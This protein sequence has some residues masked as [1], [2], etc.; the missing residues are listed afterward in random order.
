[1]AT[2]VGGCGGVH[3]G[4]ICDKFLG[5]VVEF[6]D[7][8]F[9][10]IDE[11]LVDEGRGSFRN[12]FRSCVRLFDVRS[13]CSGSDGSGEDFLHSLKFVALQFTASRFRRR[14]EAVHQSQQISSK[15]ALVRVA[16]EDLLR[17]VCVD[18]DFFTTVMVA[19][20]TEDA[21]DADFC[22][23]TFHIQRDAALRRSGFECGLCLQAID[24]NV[25]NGFVHEA[26]VKCFDACYAPLNSMSQ[27]VN[28]SKRD[29][30]LLALLEMTPATVA[31]IRRASV[32]FDD[33]P[34][35]DD[36]R[37]RERLQALSAA[38]CVQ[39]WPA[40]ISGGGMMHYHR[41]TSSGYRTLH[42]D[43]NDA[44][45]RTLVSEIA[46]SRF[47]HAMATADVIVQTLI[48]AR[49]AHIT[50]LKFH[51]DGQIT[52]S[53]GEYRQQPDCHF[54][55]GCGGR[56]F[57]VL[58][59][60]DNA[61]EPLDSQREH[62]I[63]S[64]VRGY[65]CYQDWVLRSWQQHGRVGPR[66]VFRVVFLTKGIQRVYHILALA[67]D[68]ARNPLRRLCYAA[69]QEEYLSNPLAVTSPLF[70]DHDGDWQS[71]VNLHPTSRFLREPVRIVRTVAPTGVV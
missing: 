34:F 43:R 67:R 68:C 8:F 6:A 23:G 57:N 63:R 38:G 52:L 50:V 64:K 51:G 58:Y 71:L 12:S 33:E 15:L 66:P 9:G 16:L 37:T 20:T 54:Q 10:G 13:G 49:A 3:C 1:M 29:L 47:V 24:V 19:D 61:T 46:L 53:A 27:G 28:L 2:D 45:A 35:R 5:D 18:R 7:S 21:V 69:T 14:Q 44:P 62:S 56:T 55:F 36:R 40:A 22:S 65:E 11:R 48:A 4:D 31:Q 32:T 41:L 42:P 26:S 39:S 17:V 25:S 30:G 60:V 59:E 70:I